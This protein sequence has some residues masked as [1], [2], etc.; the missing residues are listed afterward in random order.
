MGDCKKREKDNGEEPCRNNGYSPKSILS[1]VY[2]KSEQCMYHFA[3]ANYLSILYYNG[4]KVRKCVRNDVM[5][6]SLDQEYEDLM[7][8]QIR[9]EI[10]IDVDTANNS[11]NNARSTDYLNEERRLE[12][13]WERHDNFT[14]S[15]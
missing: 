6:P 13:G 1:Q 3:I 9:D 5:L 14:S 12:T 15:S 4:S 11:T 8:C 10:V 2:K 7:N